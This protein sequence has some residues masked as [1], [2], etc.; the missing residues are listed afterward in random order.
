[1]NDTGGDT[2]DDEL[3]EIGGVRPRMFL[4]DGEET[5]VGSKTR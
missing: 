5:E 3:A 4:R 2:G 1:M